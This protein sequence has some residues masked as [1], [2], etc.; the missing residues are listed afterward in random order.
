MKKNHF[1][2]LKKLKNTESARPP[3]P[4]AVQCTL[5]N[6]QFFVHISIGRLFDRIVF[7]TREAQLFHQVSHRFVACLVTICEAFRECLQL[8]LEFR[9]VYR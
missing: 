8:V 7:T 9:S 6:V 2:L 4:I 5:Y 3:L 1:L